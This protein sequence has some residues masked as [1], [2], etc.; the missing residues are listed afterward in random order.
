MNDSLNSNG[1]VLV[2]CQRARFLS[3]RS[4]SLFLALVTLAV[5][6]SVRHHDFVNFDDPDYVT[7]NP[8]IRDGITWTSLGWAF[9]TGFTGNWHPLTWVSHMLDYWLFGLRAGGHHLMSVGLHIA[10]T[11]LLFAV[12]H[13]MTRALWRSAFVAALFAWHPLHVESVAWASERKDVLSAFFFLLTIWVYVRYV[14]A[15]AQK[16]EGVL[17]NPGA[18]WRSGHR[19]SR[20]YILALLLFAL[21]LM[22]KPMLVTLP[23]V[24]VLL[25]FWPLRRFQLSATKHER[26]SL[27]LEKVPFLALSLCSSWVAFLAQ[28]RGGAVDV[29]LSLGA[30]V[31][32]ALVSYVRYL[33]AIFWPE[34]LCVFYPHPGRWPAGQ[35]FASGV[36]LLT[37]SAAVLLLW[38]KR[39]YLSVGWL[40]FVGMLFPVIGLVQVGLQALADRYTY[41][42]SI[43]LFIMVAW[44]LSEA[45]P[46]HPWR[47]KALAFAG[48]SVLAALVIVTARQVGTWRNS[49]TLF[50]HAIQVTPHNYLACDHL[51]I[52]LAMQGKLS[53]AIGYFRDAIRFKPNEPSPYSNLGKALALQHKLAEAIQE[54]QEALRL[55]PDDP[56]VLNNLGVALAMSGRADEAI[57]RFHDALRLDPAY[58]SAHRNLGKAL[59]QQ[60][61]LDEAIPEY[62][63]ALRIQPNDVEGHCQL[64]GVLAERG[65]V[66]EAVSHYTEALRLSPGYAP[67][68]RALRALDAAGMH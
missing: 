52:E 53:E 32:N 60:H 33:G 62:Q 37:V 27:W 8:H 44:G 7:E 64:A 41:L 12:L 48:I 54:D 24:L 16:V 36:V 23:F 17:A 3:P 38:R 40:W 21:G 10:N 47:T 34:N 58:A 63:E 22:S 29:S 25:D 43:G 6:F 49:E 28:K 2:S 9:Q 56:V 19:T 1:A 14:G 66:K 30:R 50:R 20:Y 13:R 57:A 35:A 5:F 26:S 39:P 51:G 46:R 11:L 68:Q 61:E 18:F 42:P 59:A 4:I 67:A 15:R 65:R 31:A 45:V 55:K